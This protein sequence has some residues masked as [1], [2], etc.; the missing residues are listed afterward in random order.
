MAP[1]TEFL[2]GRVRLVAVLL[3]AAL[4]ACPLPTARAQ[5]TRDTVDIGQNTGEPPA[6]FEFS[7]TGEG[8][9][10]PWTL[11]EDGTAA[12]GLA[13]EQRGAAPTVGHSLAIYEAAS[14]KDAEI[15]L[16]IKATDG[17]VDQGGGIALRL[18][19]P[20]NYYLLQLDARRDR[21]LFS[22]V[23][24]GVPEEIVGVDADLATNE[25]H[26]L[27]VRAAE[28]EF[29]VS[30]DGVWMLTAFDKTFLGAGRIALWT[31]ADSVTRFDNITIAPPSPSAQQW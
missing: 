7:P 1:A 17:T 10:H 30:V 19:A 27:V 5:N 4:L 22:R 24:N 9:R 20:D 13:I 29:V 8:Q 21:V 28:D 18:T 3:T 15:S 26:R 12:A 16:R 6:H 11:I 31:A 14:L 23:A 25:W 2:R